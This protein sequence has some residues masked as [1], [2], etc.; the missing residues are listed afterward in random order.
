MPQHADR[1]AGAQV[2]IHR[3]TKWTRPFTSTSTPKYPGVTTEISQ[4]KSVDCDFFRE[5]GKPYYMVKNDDAL[6]S[7][8]DAELYLRIYPDVRKAGVDSALHYLQYG[9][10]E[11]RSFFPTHRRERLTSARLSSKG[12]LG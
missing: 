12:R 11:G 6:P 1:T 10:T 5:F 4:T 8:F 3:R 7:G 9:R 2:G